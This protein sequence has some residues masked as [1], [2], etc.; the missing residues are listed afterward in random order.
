MAVSISVMRVSMRS[1]RAGRPAASV[2]GQDVDDVIEVQTQVAGLADEA[3]H[4]HVGPGV[5]A[6]TRRCAFGFGQ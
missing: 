5:E 1:T 4:R 3:Q 6:V 2:D